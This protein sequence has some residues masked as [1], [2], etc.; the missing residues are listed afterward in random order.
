M[1][2]TCCYLYVKSSDCNQ[3]ILPILFFFVFGEW[4]GRREEEKEN[5]YMV[6]SGYLIWSTYTTPTRSP[7]TMQKPHLFST[8]Y[9][10]G[11]I[12]IWAGF[13]L[14]GHNSYGEGE[15]SLGRAQKW[16]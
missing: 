10:L 13:V 15:G 1:S 11:F 14:T 5:T 9:I 7:Y 6:I 2:S 8:V 12:C 16:C 3:K 4:G